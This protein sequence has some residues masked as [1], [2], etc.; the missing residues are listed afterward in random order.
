MVQRR[1]NGNPPVFEFGGEV[2]LVRLAIWP[3]FIFLLVK[4]FIWNV[5][6]PYSGF[7]SILFLFCSIKIKEGW[8]A[9]PVIVKLALIYTGSPLH[10]FCLIKCDF[11]SCEWFEISH[12]YFWVSWL[13]L[14]YYEPILNP[15]YMYIYINIYLY[16]FAVKKI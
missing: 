7:R 14:L 1:Q 5:T 10:N 4:N 12:V 11:S 8:I 15:P 2:T 16:M 6:K 3:F 13:N 9:N